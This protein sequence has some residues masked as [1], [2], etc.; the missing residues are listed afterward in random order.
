[1]RCTNRDSRPRRSHVSHF[2]LAHRF[3]LAKGRDFLQFSAGQDQRTVIFRDEVDPLWRTIQ[4]PGSYIIDFIF[5]AVQSK[6]KQNICTST[7]V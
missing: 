3:F 2:T 6:R 5:W 7:T 4:I 1:M